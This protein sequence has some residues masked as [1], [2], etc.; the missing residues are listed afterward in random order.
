MRRYRPCEPAGRALLWQSRAR[1][2]A[3][4]QAEDCPR[5]RPRR[6]SIPTASRNEFADVR[7]PPSQQHSILTLAFSAHVFSQEMRPLNFVGS[8]LQRGA[9]HVRCLL[10]SFFCVMPCAGDKGFSPAK[11]SEM[12]LSAGCKKHRLIFMCSGVLC[13]IAATPGRGF[14]RC[15]ILREH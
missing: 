11:I 5:K 3:V 12:H 15:V 4:L 8:L 10:A 13:S 7:G 9:V 6:G 1:S 2:R 14:W